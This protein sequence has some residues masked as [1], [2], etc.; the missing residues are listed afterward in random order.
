MPEFIAAVM[1][2]TRLSRRAL[3]DHRLAEHLRVLRRRRGARL[4]LA[5]GGDAAGDRLRLGGVPLLHALEAALLGRGEALAL[6]GGDVDDDGALGLERGAQRLAD[7]AHV[8][9]V[10]DAH[11]GPVE[12]LPPQAGLPERLDRLLDL[13]PE[14]LERGADPARQTRELL[15][16]ALAGLPQP[17]VEPDAVEV[18][19]QRTD[20]RR[21]RHPVVVEDHDHRRAEAAGLVDRLERDTTGHGAV[22]DDGDD[23][24]VIPRAVP[25]GLL[26]AHG[27]ADGGRCVAG[28][29]DVVLGL[30]DRAE[31]G[32]AAV[33]ADRPELVAAAGEDLVRIGLV[34]DVPHD[35]VARRVEQRV[36]GYRDLARAEVGAEVPADLADRVDQQLA[37]LLRDLLQLVLGEPVQVLR[38][39][40]AVEDRFGHEE[41]V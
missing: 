6:H 23:L 20:V 27:V 7:R 29:H 36:H 24:A 18:A 5:R 25:H 4:G 21:D 16:D 41:R 37:H 22:A 38:A 19:R 39:V 1:P 2:T 31:R 9:A 26:E 40:D 34:A 33:L 3:L 17:R 13:W 8:V 15:L 30:V 12:L 35:L 10:D 28:A 11:V 32:Q 14:A